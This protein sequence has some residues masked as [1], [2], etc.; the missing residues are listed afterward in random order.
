MYKYLILFVFFLLLGGNVS[1]QRKKKPAPNKAQVK[2]V[3]VKKQ[4]EPTLYTLMLPSADKVMVI[5]SVVADK[6]HF[7]ASLP[8]HE[9][10]GSIQSAGNEVI[11]TNE[12]DN[13]RIVAQGDS[14]TGRRLYS[15]L[16]VG[17]T[18]SQ[19]T[20]INEL[21][22][23]FEML[24]F[25]FLMS[26]GLTLFF[27]AKGSKSIGGYD[28]F[29]TRF[30][31]EKGTYYIPENYGLPYNSTANDYLLAI[32]DLN[33]LGWLV[34]DRFQP[35]DKVCIYTFLPNK[36]RS[37]LSEESLSE[38]QKQG[39]AD[40]TNIADTWRFGDRNAAINRLRELKN[41][42]LKAQAANKEFSF[43]VN[44][45]REYH[46]LGDF[47]SSKARNLFV[48]WRAGNKEQEKMQQQLDNLRSKYAAATQASV[49]RTLQAEIL[50][51]ENSVYEHAKRLSA[52]EREL[53][54]IENNTINH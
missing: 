8:L 37:K 39:L 35:A 24:E 12:F 3:V 32:D 28:I 43:V 11:Y 49:K 14:I 42:L 1:A 54:N 46:T 47:K 7:L 50:N 2:T 31:S 36:N 29:T 45:A 26:D 5:D 52:L 22:Q 13:K 30:D 44:D 33:N 48:Q 6:A 40:L 15:S 41:N 34:S 25:P 17:E 9:G 20:P 19:P 16:K 21:N 51:L 38:V 18:W 53:R 27:A 4:P 23:E 10:C